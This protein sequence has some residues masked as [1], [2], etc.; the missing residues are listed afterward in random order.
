MDFHY[1]KNSLIFCFVDLYHQTLTPES[2]NPI[3]PVKG[4]KVRMLNSVSKPY[5]H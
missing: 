5:W 1:L 3:L 4:K 2:I